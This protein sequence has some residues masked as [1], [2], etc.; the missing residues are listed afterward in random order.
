MILFLVMVAVVIVLNRVWIYDWFR[1]LTYRP[2]VEA[3]K[4]KSDL[5][6]TGRGEFLFNATQPVLSDAGEFNTNCRQNEDEVAVLGC[7]TGGNIYIYNIVSDEL[8]GIRELTAAHE[9]LH[10]V[11]ARMSGSEQ[12]DLTES[13]TR[14]FEKN[15]DLLGPEIEPYDITEKQ[16][17]LYVRAGTEVKDLPEDLERHFAEIFRNQDRIVDFYESYITVFREMKAQME[18]LANEMESIKVEI[19]DKKVEYENV[20]ADLKADIKK[21]NSC[22]E[23]AGCFGSER[24]FYRQRS[25]LVTR[26]DELDALSDEINDLVNTYN[27]KVD[28]YNADVTESRKLQDMINS[29]AE[30]I[31]IK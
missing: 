1:G 16:E 5:G 28:E 2:T 12:R 24:E 13:L 6:L 7:Y 23:A 15:Q 10:A 22:A 17:E 18:N 29:K 11:W 19:D 26:Q 21:F 3:V 30:T 31:E 9:L 27:M 25:A 20:L 4:I 14:V 8:Q